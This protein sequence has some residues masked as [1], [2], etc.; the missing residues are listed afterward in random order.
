MTT[1]PPSSL[2]G[3]QDIATAPPPP[4]GVRRLL[5]WPPLLERGLSEHFAVRD[6]CGG[7]F[8]HPTH[9]MPLNPPDP[10]S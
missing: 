4:D 3:W 5:Y 9:W 6:D 8:R 2:V 10:S 1:S 7:P